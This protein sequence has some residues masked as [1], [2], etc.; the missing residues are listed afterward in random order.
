MLSRWRHRRKC[1]ALAGQSNDPCLTS[2]I[3][4]CADLRAEDLDQTPLISVDL[5]LTGLDARQN[6]IIAIG[7]TQLD[8][9]RLRFGSN[10]H[11]LINAQQSVGHSAAIHELLDSDVAGGLPLDAALGELFDAAQGRV[12]LFHHANLDIAFLRQACVSWAG[13]APPFIVLD[14]M[15]MELLLRK[16]REIPVQHGDLQL[17]KLRASYKLPRYTAHNALID[18]CATAELL[19]AIAAKMDPAGSLQLSPYVKYY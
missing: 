2:Y 8:N 5:E 6:Q 14:T 19:L 1:R 16:R 10:R 12:W 4:A 13:V 17:S 18:A 9:G 15:R 11:L 7:W 3:D